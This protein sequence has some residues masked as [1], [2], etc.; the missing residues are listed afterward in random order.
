MFHVKGNNLLDE[1]LAVSGLEMALDPA[2][3]TLIATGVSTVAQGIFGASQADNQNRQA[4]KAAELKYEYDKLRWK[5][6]KQR[7]KRD[8]K[9]LVSKILNEE[10]N[11]D[12]MRAYKDQ[13]AVNNYNYGLQIQAYE[14]AIQDRLFQKSEDLYV[15]SVN[16][17]VAERNGAK[18]SVVEEL[19][20]TYRAAAFDNEDTILKSLAAGGAA[21]V[22]GGVGRSAQMVQQAQ[23]AEFGRDQAI[24][25]TSLMSAEKKAQGDISAINKQFEDALIRADANRMLPPIPKPIPPAPL[26][27]PDMTFMLPP[28]LQEFDFGPKP[29]KG[30]AAYT[31]PALSFANAAIGALPSIAGGIAGLSQGTLGGGGTTYGSGAQAP[32]TGGI[33]YSGAFSGGNYSPINPFGN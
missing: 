30:V 18:D 22:R 17:A 20:D 3:A 4:A 23:L 12:R 2:T 25:A 6:G 26:P 27:T 10:A 29:I 1:Q 13:T 21:A 32:L 7:T 19:K 24:L 15:K 16:S 33:D 14:K 8:Y 28:E 9:Y 11:F 5:Q 31:N